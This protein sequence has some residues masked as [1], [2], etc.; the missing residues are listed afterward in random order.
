MGIVCGCRANPFSILPL[1]NFPVNACSGA[2]SWQGMN[3][4]YGHAASLACGLGNISRISA[5]R[6]LIEDLQ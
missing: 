1:G 3:S 5:Y 6:N 4:T 2:D